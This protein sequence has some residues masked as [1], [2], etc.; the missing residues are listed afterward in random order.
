MRDYQ[1]DFITLYKAFQDSENRLRKSEKFSYVLRKLG[2]TRIEGNCLDIGSSNGII[3]NNLSPYFKNVLGIDIDMTAMK[4]IDNSQNKNIGY[5]VADAM[6]LPFY[7]NSFEAV[8]CSQTYEHV[9]SSDRLF[10]EIYRILKPGGLLVFSGPNKTYPI[11]MHYNLPFLHWF[12]EKTADFYLQLT[13]KGTH[14][15]ER[16]RTYWDLNKVFKDYEI[17]DVVKY[18]LEFYAETTNK[19]IKRRIYRAASLLPIWVLKFV[20]PFLVNINWILIKSEMADDRR[21]KIVL[22][23]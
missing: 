16:S 19:P 11:E 5:A 15:Y 6:T 20:S 7:H 2:F 10:S 18:V 14:Y 3:T 13:K 8:V 21:G 9:P 1:E 12:N 22:A 23:S 17:I 4:L